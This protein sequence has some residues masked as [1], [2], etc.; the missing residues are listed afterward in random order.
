MTLEDLRFDIDKIDMKITSLLNQ[1][2]EKALLTKKLKKIIEDTG[3]EKL[4]LDKIRHSS[5]CLLEPDF[6]EGLYK[7]IKIGRAHV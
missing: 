5:H 3:R 4:V 2:I 7:T 1:R 6:A